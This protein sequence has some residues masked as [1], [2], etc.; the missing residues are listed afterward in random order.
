MLCNI[1]GLC[2]NCVLF[3]LCRKL[4]QESLTH[5]VPYFT[6]KTTAVCIFELLRWYTSQVYCGS[7]IPNRD[8][9]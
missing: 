7:V 2:E 3:G 8:Q 6:V 5:W 1:N 9:I 4:L